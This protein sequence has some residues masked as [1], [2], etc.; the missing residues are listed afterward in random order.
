VIDLAA[1]VGWTVGFLVEVSADIDKFTFRC[2][3]SNKEKFITNGMWA[4]CRQ[5]NYFGEILMWTSVALS[6]SCTDSAKS[7][8]MFSWISPIFT[9]YLLLFVSGVPMVEAAGKK[10]WGENPEYLHY[11]KNTNLLIPG[12][13]APKMT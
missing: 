1:L 2:D 3:P 8:L 11:M 9:A 12:F 5:P 4:Y 6:V 13:R 7:V 10:K